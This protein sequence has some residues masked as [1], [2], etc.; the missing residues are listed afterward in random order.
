M[1]R[2]TAGFHNFWNRL[3]YFRVVTITDCLT[4]E[5]IIEAKQTIC[6]LSVEDKLPSCKNS[7]Y[8]KESTTN[9]NNVNSN[10]D[11]V[12]YLQN[13]GFPG[14]YDSNLFILIFKIG[15][16]SRCPQ[17][18]SKSIY[19]CIVLKVNSFVMRKGLF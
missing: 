13:L 3:F 11:T 10:Y 17:C 4:K 15:R 18:S 8:F 12:L 14:A 6:I 7:Q 16:K 19:I 1:P 5:D 2:V 9:E